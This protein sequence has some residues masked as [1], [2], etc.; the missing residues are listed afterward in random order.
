MARYS[1]ASAKSEETWYEYS[2]MSLAITPVPAPSSTTWNGE[3]FPIIS[4]IPASCTV[5]SAPK[6]G[7]ATGLV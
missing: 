6:A 1:K 3:G 2:I 4:H 7:C 5:S